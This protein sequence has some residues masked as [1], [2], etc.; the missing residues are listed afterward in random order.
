[1]FREL[2][3]AARQRWEGVL[4]EL[5]LLAPGGAVK[6]EAV[7][8]WGG[9]D[10][11]G[12]QRVE[13]DMSPVLQGHSAHPGLSHQLGVVPPAQ[14]MILAAQGDSTSPGLFQQLRVVSPA[15]GYSPSPG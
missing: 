8:L 10:T 13:A 2:I 12:G 6:V 11:L 1:M 14:E 9:S 4:G 3:G 7:T 15:Q 5:G